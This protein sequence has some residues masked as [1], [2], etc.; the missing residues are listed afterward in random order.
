MSR[1]V[2]LAP[3]P[4]AGHKIKNKD[5]HSIFTSRIG[6][7]YFIN[8]DST[9]VITVIYQ[10]QVD[11]DERKKAVDEI[12]KLVNPGEPVKLLV[13]VRKIVMI[14]S[15]DEQRYFAKYLADKKELSDARVA[16][17]HVPENN[18][19]LLISAVAYSEGYKIVDFDN[20][21]YANE[22]LIGNIR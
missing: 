21:N 5:T 10:G 1:K 6:M 16:V 14:M 18:P 17:V 4:C 13:D 11:L 20:L 7:P 3:V 9:S 15:K 19:N 22:W 2:I 12:C 8:K